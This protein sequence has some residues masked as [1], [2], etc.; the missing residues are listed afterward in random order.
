M[1]DKNRAE[2]D[3]E[4]SEILQETASLGGEIVVER[5]GVRAIFTP[6]CPRR[7][8]ALCRG[9]TAIPRPN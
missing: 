1:T 6:R 3:V 7:A 5:D 2:I 8:Q 4:D 9:R